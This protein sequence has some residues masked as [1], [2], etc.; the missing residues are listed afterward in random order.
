MNRKG[1]KVFKTDVEDAIDDLVNDIC[2]KAESV[3]ERFDISDSSDLWE[4]SDILQ[5]HLKWID[6]VEKCKSLK[7]VEDL[8]KK[9]EFALA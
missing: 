7:A 3:R 6:R 5:T 4:L 1:Q 9:M 8:H 2:E